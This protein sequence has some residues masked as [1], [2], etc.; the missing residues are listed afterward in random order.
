VNRE[1]NNVHVALHG[2]L[3][4]LVFCV[5]V[6]A[7]FRAAPYHETPAA[8]ITTSADCL[9]SGNGGPCLPFDKIQ[10]MM[11]AQPDAPEAIPPNPATANEEKI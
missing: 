10:E 11:E 5:V 3:A 2:T 6:A 1:N 9:P 7:F 4:A 8:P